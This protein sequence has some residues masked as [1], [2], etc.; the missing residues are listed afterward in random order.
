MK[1][2]TILAITLLLGAFV[3][4]RF[5]ILR[6]D[7]KTSSGQAIS[8]VVTENST[9]AVLVV[10]DPSDRAFKVAAY[11]Y[12]ASNSKS[13]SEMYEKFGEKLDPSKTEP[14][15]K[16]ALKQNY[17]QAEIDKFLV[18]KSRNSTIR[19]FAIYLD[20]NKGDLVY[21]ESLR[22]QG[23]AEKSKPTNNYTYETPV[24]SIDTTDLESKI[25]VIEKKQKDL[26]FDLRMDCLNNGGVPMGIKCM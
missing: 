26:E 7:D 16:N 2:I 11:V 12:S 6:K 23:L 15:V 18:E 9:P 22:E 17:S 19:G 21:F 5:Q 25:D 4:W 13:K 8:A 24:Q 10:P 3:F 1:T 14:F 20:L